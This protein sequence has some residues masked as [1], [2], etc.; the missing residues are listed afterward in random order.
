MAKPI[1]KIKTIYPSIGSASDNICANRSG[2][3]MGRYNIILDPLENGELGYNA[4]NNGLYIGYNGTNYLLSV[5]N[6]NKASGEVTGDYFYGEASYANKATRLKN[7]RTITLQGDATGSFTFDGS[8]DEGVQV[9]VNKSAS[10]TTAETADKLTTARTISLTGNATGSASFDGSGDVSI[11]TTV[12]NAQQA[13]MLTVGKIG[14]TNKPVYFNN[15]VPTP[16]SYTIKKSVPSNA[17]FTDTT[18]TAG[19]GLT[20]DGTTFNHNSTFENE[21]AL[22]QSTKALKFGESFMVPSIKHDAMGHL[23]EAN[24]STITLPSDRLFVTL[25]PSGTAIEANSDLNTVTFLKVGRY[26]CSENK[27]A[28]TLKNCP[29]DKAFMMEVSSPLSPIIDNEDKTYVYRLRKITHYSTGVQYIQYC[30]T[31]SKAGVWSYGKWYIV[32]RSPFTIDSTDKNSG[33]ASLGSTIRPVYVSSDGTL[34]AVTEPADSSKASAI[35]T[36]QKLVTE[37]D[38][39][40]GLPTLNGKHDYTSD[41]KYYLPTTGGQQGNLLVSDGPDSA[42]IWKPLEWLNLDQFVTKENPTGNLPISFGRLQGSQIGEKSIAI[43]LDSIASNEYTTAIGYMTKATGSGSLAM[44]VNSEASGFGS[45]SIG[46]MTKATSI[47]QAVFGTLNIPDTVNA[48]GFSEH[49]FIIGNSTDEENLSNALTVDW[50]GNLWVQ[51]NVL[52]GDNKKALAT[53]D[54][55]TSLETS[56]S[57]EIKKYLPLTGN[58]ATDQP[59]MTGDVVF[60]VGGKHKNLGIKWTSVN[61]KN[62]YIGYATDQNDGTFALM[63]IEGTTYASGLAIGGSSGS[64]LWKG[65]KVL[66]VDSEENASKLTVKHAGTAT[67]AT[68]AQKADMLTIGKVGDTNKPVYFDAGIPKEATG[69]I[70]T[71]TNLVNDVNDLGQNL[72]GKARIKH[73]SKDNTYGLGNST[74]YGHLKL[75]DSKDD[76]KSGVDQGVAATPKAV[77]SVYTYA[78]GIETAL[79]S[80]LTKTEASSTYATKGYA[81]TAEA[82]AIKTSKKY[83]D[84]EIDKIIG[85]TSGTFKSLLTLE[86]LITN[87]SNEVDNIDADLATKATTT[88]LTNHI[89]DTVKHITSTERNNWNGKTQVQFIVWGEND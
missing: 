28:A 36:D 59:K 33:D 19:T 78:K 45:V 58:S 50:N 55:V 8:R 88:A 83:T 31:S 54:S 46:M 18:Y 47:G 80:Y 30:C 48:D 25:T 14:A 35:G 16:I 63:S 11:N 20:L 5:T 21:G 2:E 65:K 53:Q 49:V 9:T 86:Q 41:S 77:N 44:G 13:D 10:A 75:S 57:N 4:W 64:L 26:Y 81:D 62:P 42:P 32:P 69:F 51:G 85:S 82:D 79:D 15:G 1:I 3:E 76:D 12:I 17:V 70:S 68:S 37:R 22:L 38:I 52:I 61:N 87:L 7:T 24:Q 56:L 73:D 72:A 6:G 40:Y 71:V 43:G 84:D 27:N 66:T 34:A 67:S 23:T 89:N 74:N 29:I 39:Y 60:D